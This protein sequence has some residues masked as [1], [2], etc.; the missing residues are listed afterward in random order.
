MSDLLGMFI[1]RALLRKRK[2]PR[3]SLAEPHPDDVE[4]LAELEEQ[5]SRL[6]LP[7][8]V[9]AYMAFENEKAAWEAVESLRKM[10]YQCS[11]RADQDGRW[12]VTAVM[13]MVPSQGGITYL[14]EEL[15]K[16]GAEVGGSY[17]GWDAPIVA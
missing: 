9:R 4:R 10:G 16:L 6:R 8:P 13:S 14:R 2:Q 15:E 5:G 12:T 1:P 7:H 17:L 3:I 11:V